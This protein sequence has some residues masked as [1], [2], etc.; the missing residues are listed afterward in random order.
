MN[1]ISF[2]NFFMVHNDYHFRAVY[3]FLI[4]II[5]FFFW[6]GGGGGGVEVGQIT[7]FF[8][9]DPAIIF[10][11]KMSSGFYVWCSNIQVHYILSWKQTL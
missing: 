11:L 7:A 2:Y 6:G 3:F 9:F 4:I 10:V 1:T 5:I 8:T